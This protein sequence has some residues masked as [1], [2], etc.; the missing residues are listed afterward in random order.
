MA[1]TDWYL[2]GLAYGN[3]NCDYGCPCQFEKRPTNGSCIGF[4]AHRI[5]K[6]HFGEVDLSGLRSALLY[7]WPGAVFE[8]NGE[9]QVVI[10]ES[11]SPEQRAA[12]LEIFRGAETDEAAT[13]WWVYHAMCKTEHE[14][15]FLK[16]D[17]DAD[18]DS[19]TARVFIDGVLESEGRPIKPPHGD[20]AHRVRID[21]PEGIEFAV[22][23]IGSAS[24]TATAAIKFDLR[25]SYGQWNVI[26]MNPQGVVRS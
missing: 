24:T 22:A 14:P 5:D 13:H 25:D 20:G 23:E 16:I 1:K 19:R 12:L 7:S 10:D 15:V 2:E 3:C 4:E 21:M 6:G 9:M 17:F 8:G 26:R 11:A 18:L